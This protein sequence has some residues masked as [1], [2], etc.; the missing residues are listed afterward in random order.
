MPA[1]INI[2][3]RRYGRLVV[4]ELHAAVTP[5]C[6]QRKWVCRCDCGTHKIVAVSSLI[7]GHA[8][9][10]GCLYRETRPWKHGH[11][12][13]NR[14]GSPTYHSWTCMINRCTRAN[15][16]AFRWYGGRGITVCE[17][18]LSFVNFLTDMGERPPGKTLDRKDNDGNYEKGNCQWA[19][20]REQASNRR[21]SKHKRSVIS[22]NRQIVG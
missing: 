17:R 20:R 1:A 21:S 5:T 9:S 12:R 3:G 8:Q 19:T 13:L 18:W 15:H 2:I 4:V 22:A 6:R 7:N 14:W 11:A 10:C 16:E